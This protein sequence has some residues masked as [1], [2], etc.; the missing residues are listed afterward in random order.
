MARD[1]KQCPECGAE[2][3]LPASFDHGTDIK[4]PECGAWIAVFRP[5]SRMDDE[6]GRRHLAR[7][8]IGIVTVTVLLL[9]LVIVGGAGG[10]LWYFQRREMQAARLAEMD[11]RQAEMQARAASLPAAR[12]GNVFV[13][14]TEFPLQTEDYAEARKKFKTKLLREGPAPQQPIQIQVPPGVTEIN[15][16]SGDLLLKAWVSSDPGPGPEKK[17]AILYLHNGFAF[18]QDDWEQAAPFRQAGYVVMIPILRGENGQPGSY[19]LFYN[20]VD[21][22]L[23]AANALE[24]LSYVDSKRIY[25]AGHSNGG[26]LTQ[27]VAMTSPRFRAASSFSGSP[28]QVNWGVIR[29]NLGS[30]GGDQTVG[31][32]FDKEDQKEVQM[33]SPLAF[34]ASFKCPVRLYFGSQEATLKASNEKIAELAKKKNLDVQ[35]IEVPGDHLTAVGPA[36]QQCIDFFQKH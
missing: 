15:H 29:R 20:E 33:R 11:A 2:I 17:P 16:V 32:P 9:L 3:P 7:L 10:F 18:G 28:D 4:C 13:P 6:S 30:F 19:S 31:I 22:I 24:E 14:P 8:W 36:M 5:T 34:P 21:D 12:L 23:A 1:T 26:T 27:L 25:L 35:A